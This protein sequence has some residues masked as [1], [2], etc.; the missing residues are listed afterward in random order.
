MRSLNSAP[1]SAGFIRFKAQPN[2]RRHRKLWVYKLRSVQKAAQE[3]VEFY[4]KTPLAVNCTR[5][6][7]L[8]GSRYLNLRDCNE[9]RDTPRPIALSFCV[10]VVN[11]VGTGNVKYQERLPQQS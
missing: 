6:H 1:F 2:S 8:S 10:T 3:I 4:A 7:K 9:D 5:R 11:P